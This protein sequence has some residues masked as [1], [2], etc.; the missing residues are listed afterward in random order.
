M[1]GMPPGESQVVS[2]LENML[3]KYLDSN[4][5]RQFDEIETRAFLNVVLAVSIQVQATSIPG[6]I[7]AFQRCSK[8][9]ISKLFSSGLRRTMTRRFPNILDFKLGIIQN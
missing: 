5:G 9:P 3:K 7:S 6:T 4:S 2:F 8:C 1:S